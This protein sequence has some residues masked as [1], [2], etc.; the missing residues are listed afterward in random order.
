MKPTLPYLALFAF[1]G[2]SFAGERVVTYSRTTQTEQEPRC[3]GMKGAGTP[4]A[5]Y[6]SNFQRNGVRLFNN[7]QDY[8]TF[9]VY[10]ADLPGPNDVN[11]MIRIGAQVYPT[12]MSPYEKA[13]IERR[14]THYWV[15]SKPGR[16][17]I[18][19]AARQLVPY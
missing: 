2:S 1:A 8:M 14:G 3:G 19:Q 16:W 7:T 11:E 12:V 4:G 5:F 13:L 6:H 18:D 9:F 15:A 10:F 17:R